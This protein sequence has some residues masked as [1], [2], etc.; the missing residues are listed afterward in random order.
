M[1]SRRR[2]M[3]AKV[4]VANHLLNQF[5]AIEEISK[6]LPRDLEVF[7]SESLSESQDAWMR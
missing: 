1:A 7:R 4:P 3:R 2:E 5:M 6:I